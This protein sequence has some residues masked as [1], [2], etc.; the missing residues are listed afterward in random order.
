[1]AL[2]FAD[3]EFAA[4]GELRWHPE[5]KRIRAFVD[6]EALSIMDRTDD[7][8]RWDIV[9]TVARWK[10]L[11]EQQGRRIDN[12]LLDRARA[13]AREAADPTAF[14]TL[15]EELSAESAEGWRGDPRP[16]GRLIVPG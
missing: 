12:D 7:R 6:G 11:L 14:T 2:R 8:G 10:F 13:V 3:H 1:M 4:L 5:A 16:A 9:W 15:L